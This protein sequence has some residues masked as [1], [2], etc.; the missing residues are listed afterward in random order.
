MKE[1]QYKKLRKEILTFKP[2][3]QPFLLWTIYKMAR[4]DPH[5]N[6]EFS[7]E[8]RLRGYECFCHFC[9]CW[10]NSDSDAGMEAHGKITEGTK[11]KMRLGFT[12]EFF[13]S[14]QIT[15]RLYKGTKQ[16]KEKIIRW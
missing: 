1:K 14:Y 11:D 12:V 8:F 13:P 9:V 4:L 5:L 2:V 15:I 7:E 10:W 3:Y 16:T 6:T